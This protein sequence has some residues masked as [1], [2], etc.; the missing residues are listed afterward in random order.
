MVATFGGKK[1]R[2]HWVAAA[3]GLAL[4]LLPGRVTAQDP[5]NVTEAREYLAR[6]RL[7]LQQE[8][9][10]AALAEFERAYQLVGEHPARHQILFNI[11]RAHERLFRYDL[12][13]QYFRRYLDEA[14][15]DA[16]ERADAEATIRAL[17]G[18]LGTVEVAS[19]V[20]AEIWVDNRNI[21]QAPGTVRVPSGRHVMELRAQGYTDGRREFQIAS[22][23]TQ[24]LSFTLTA[25]AAEYRG[26][27]AA[28]FW[29]TTGLA[30]A[31]ALA[32]GG[33]GI[34]ALMRRSDVDAQRV[35]PV[36]MLDGGSLEA[37]RD[38]IASLQLTADVLFGTAGLFAVTATV[39]AF[40]TD[41]RGA[42][43]ESSGPAASL[44]VDPILAPGLA[45][46]SVGGGF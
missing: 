4:A 20:P 32:G 12:A 16:A 15:A 30:I 19:N 2:F 3:L 41:W 25:L 22:R 45:G 38:E 7:L 43:S 6:G 10:D 39:L 31:A 26:L 37:A 27:D 9:F 35:D 46:L 40:L 36:G 13:L 23:E 17:E 33:V 8:N 5:A 21:G 28:F 1:M 34:A 14:P 18:L 11:A 29:G 42:P 24:S 44:R